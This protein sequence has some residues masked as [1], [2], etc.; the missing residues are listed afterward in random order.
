[1]KVQ[2]A[3]HGL[4]VE[5]I[6]DGKPFNAMLEMVSGGRFRNGS[7]R[8]CR[9]ANRRSSLRLA[10]AGLTAYNHNLDTSP[11]HYKNIIT[12]RTYQDRLDTIKRVRNAGMFVVE[13]Y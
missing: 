8:Y 12:T 13:V 7:M 1:M 2:I 10:D 6:R 9:D 3:W 5:R 4:G 11:E